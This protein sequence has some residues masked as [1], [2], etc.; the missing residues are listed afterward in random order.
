[1]P[2]EVLRRGREQAAVSSEIDAGDR[3]ARQRP[4]AP[5]KEVRP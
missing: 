5:P 4:G 3:I 1:V 2:V